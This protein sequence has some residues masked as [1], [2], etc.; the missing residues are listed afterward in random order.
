MCLDFGET[1]DTD[2]SAWAGE[3]CGIP[4]PAVAWGPGLL[5]PAL[6]GPWLAD[7]AT[8][9]TIGFWLDPDNKG[10][11]ERWETEG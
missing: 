7:P 9:Q 1:Q 10:T 3:N 6:L 2:G 8:P 11:S 4:H 5:F